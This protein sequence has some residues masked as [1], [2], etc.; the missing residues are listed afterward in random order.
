MSGKDDVVRELTRLNVD[1]V[2]WEQDREPSDVE[3]LSGCLS[4]DLVFRRADGRVVGKEA[5]MEGLAGP[6]PFDR[7]EAHVVSVQPVG[8]RALVTLTVVT[9][10]EDARRVY[11][12]LRF[13]SSHAGRWLLD[14]WFNDDV[15]SFAGWL[16]LDDELRAGRWP[17]AD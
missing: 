17:P 3:Q 6:S 15:T 4:P 13:F 1:L 8:D 14:A 5:F 12:N 11:R 10:K 9:E 16:G 2:R 7:R